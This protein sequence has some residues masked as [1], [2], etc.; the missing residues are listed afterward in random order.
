MIL[1]TSLPKLLVMSITDRKYVQMPLI[2]TGT[3]KKRLRSVVISCL[4]V[5]DSFE[6]IRLHIHT[7]RNTQWYISKIYMY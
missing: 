2:S 1:F 6:G 7:E 5:G 4:E 3:D